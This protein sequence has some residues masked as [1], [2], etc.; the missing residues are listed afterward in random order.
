MKD[1]CCYY[2]RF[3]HVYW[4]GTEFDGCECRAWQDE[5]ELRRYHRCG[6]SLDYAASRRSG[7][8]C[9]RFVYFPPDEGER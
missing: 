4:K 8:D 2:C 6:G 5:E 9:S 1:R 7:R 3:H